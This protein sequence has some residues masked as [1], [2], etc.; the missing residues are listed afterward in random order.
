MGILFRMQTYQV[1]ERKKWCQLACELMICSISVATATNYHFIFKMHN[2]C[3]INTDHPCYYDF[4]ECPEKKEWIVESLHYCSFS[5]LFLLIRKRVSSRILAASKM[6]KQTSNKLQMFFG[7][8]SSENLKYNL[9]KILWNML[10]KNLCWS[11]KGFFSGWQY[12]DCNSNTQHQQ[13]EAIFPRPSIQSLCLSCL[14]VGCLYRLSAYSMTHPFIPLWESQ[15]EASKELCPHTIMQPPTNQPRVQLS[16]SAPIELQAKFLLIL[17]RQSVFVPAFI[18]AQDAFY[19]FK[20]GVHSV[21]HEEI[22]KQSTWY[23]HSHCGRTFKLHHPGQIHSSIRNA[24]YQRSSTYGALCRLVSSRFPHVG[25]NL[26]FYTQSATV[27][28]SL[29]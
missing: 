11:F 27:L 1:V 28:P 4:L 26:I 20:V 10:K 23:Q 3:C 5:K 6:G 22:Q 15:R 14:P 19:P 13:S 16:A 2:F 24:Q 7:K 18:P 9:W 17:R 21:F 8:L 12:L 29:L 25:V